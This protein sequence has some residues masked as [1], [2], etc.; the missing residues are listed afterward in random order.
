MVTTLT[1]V[2]DAAGRLVNADLR[3]P[4]LIPNYD[5]L[6]FI[7]AGGFGDVWLARERVT[8]VRRAVKVL[9]KSDAARAA[10]DIAGVRRYQGCANNHPHLLQI[11]TV[12]ET[13]R[14]FYYVM[15]AADDSTPLTP[16]LRV[17]HDRPDS[18]PSAAQMPQD[19]DAVATYQ[20][21]T[22]RALMADKGRF[23][24]RAALELIQKLAS[25][26][27]RLHEQHLA[28]FDLKPE[29]V[30]IVEGEPRIADVGLVGSI[31]E[32]PPHAGTPTY[33]TPQGAADDLYALG[34]ILYELVS[35]RPPTDFP[36]L[37][38][39]LSRHPT[40]E[41]TA[42]LG[43]V[44][45][46]CHTN[47]DKRCSTIDEVQH[48]VERALSWS[49]RRARRRRLLAVGGLTL[50]AAALGLSYTL[51]QEEWDYS[52][53]SSATG[54]MYTRFRVRG[55]RI[56]PNALR[57][58]EPLTITFDYKIKACGTHTIYLGVAAWSDS[59]QCAYLGTCYR[60]QPGPGGVSS[61]CDMTVPAPPP[62]DYVVSA[63]VAHVRS[64]EEMVE[65]VRR[66]RVDT[67]RI[68][69]LHITDGAPAP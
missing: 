69:T 63:V 50:L 24:A 45:Q 37:P 25:G 21:L 51:F 11:L 4:G 27:A 42:A 57:P 33:M 3:D 48:S 66:E 2:I 12:G 7:K 23:D 8:G 36:R 64:E 35:G 18:D 17:Q 56:R 22:L 15:A 1:H 31:G 34:R 43:M 9:H 6:A 47:A 32:P 60:G 5:L 53:G 58:G 46:I 52:V 13:E 62:G 68:G 28:H 14:C 41:L 10:R 44:N 67:R 19:N 61:T 59:L 38:P 30:L 65:T 54:G 26:V 40:R 29:N 55:E 49:V 20:A 16:D 39:E